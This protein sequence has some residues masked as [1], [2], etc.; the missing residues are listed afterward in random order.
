MRCFIESTKPVKNERK[1]ADFVV[2][3]LLKRK[4]Y[5][6]SHLDAYAGWT[7]ST[8]KNYRGG[9]AS[10]VSFLEEEE[11]IWEDLNSPEDIQRILD[12]FSA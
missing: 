7:E 10:F 4:L 11:L 12:D 5:R 1:R 3:E 8:L 6:G 9:W 2:R